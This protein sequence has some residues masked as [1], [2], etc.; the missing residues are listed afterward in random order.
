MQ[1]RVKPKKRAVNL[2]VDADLLAE[3]KN[4]GLNLSELL[5]ATLRERI[6]Q[7]RWDGWRAENKAAIE[8]MNRFVAKNGLLSDKY[9]VR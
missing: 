2:T 1:E 7:Q 8:S 6:R 5:E 9:R 3:A 4:A